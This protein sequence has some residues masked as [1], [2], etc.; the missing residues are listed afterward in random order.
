[1]KESE[2]LKRDMKIVEFYENGS[3]PHDIGKRVGLRSDM[4]RK[5]LKNRGY[6][7]DYHAPSTTGYTIW[8][9]SDDKRRQAIWDRARRAA[10]AALQEVA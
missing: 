6:V 10:H 9:Q 4:V 2:R 3:S 8:E 1:M 7:F 5:I